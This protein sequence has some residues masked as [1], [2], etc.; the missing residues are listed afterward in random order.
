MIVDAEILKELRLGAGEER[1]EKAE[2][3]VKEKRVNITKVVY[4]DFRNFELRA[5]VKE[6][7]GIYDV[8]IQVRQGEIENVSCTCPDYETHYATCKH[9][10]ATML[11]FSQNSN[12]VR[13]FAGD[14]SI[15][16]ND[17]AI[18]KNYQNKK[19]EEKYRTFKKLIH[20]FYPTNQVE[21]TKKQEIVVP[22]TIRIE[23]QLIY[24]SYRKNLKLAVKIGDKQLYKLKNLPEFYERML[25]KEYYRYGAKLA[26]VHTEEA[27]T[28]ESKELLQY[29]LKYAEIM[30]YANEAGEYTIYGKNITDGYI[31]ISN[32]GLDDLFD[33]LKGKRILLQKEYAEGNILLED[34]E[35]DIQFE[36]EK[37]DTSEYKLVPNIDIYNYDLLEGKKYIYFLQDHILYRCNK[38][39]QETT[40]E[41]LQVFRNN[42]TNEIIF[43]KVELPQ[44]FSVV[45]PKVREHMDLS[46]VEEKE[47]EAY[48]P[49]ELY[50]K[51]FLDF[52]GNNHITADIKFVYGDTEFNP[53]AEQ[54]E[55]VARDVIKE[56]EIL[57][58]FRKTGFMLDTAHQRLILVK[59]DAIYQFLS[60]EIEE[61]MQ[62]FEVLATQ[63][64]KEKE[65]KEPQI[66]N[67]GVRIENQLLKI[68][69]SQLDFD[70]AELKEI[71]TKYKLKKKYHRLK[72]GSFLNLEE[73]ETMTEFGISEFSNK[74]I[75]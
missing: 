3:Y 42:F 50:V 13:I 19:R 36:I 56:D 72:D 20:T 7:Q 16:E 45:F 64:F 53:L 21:D 31:T 25:N 58:T 65:I 48:I 55:T 46:K 69:F 30:K 2:R 38:K 5:R 35:P 27:F 59:E 8:Y 75:F 14:K 60:Q 6:N 32:T 11:E 24:D 1:I 15:Q 54:K 33:I 73:N 70:P 44:L 74:T 37:I 39:F 52:D 10:L 34:K 43:P 61:Y 41:L 67:L 51:V 17:F 26:F 47:I 18:Y 4:D 23:P 62:K 68:D 57:E 71:M 22:H 40:L 29:I 49:Q 63:N 66:G 9:V 28:Q 12:Y